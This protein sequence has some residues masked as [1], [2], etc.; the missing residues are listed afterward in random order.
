MPDTTHHTAKSLFKRQIPEEGSNAARL[1]E[2][3]NKQAFR[4]E[5]TRLAEK[6]QRLE[7][8]KVTPK[9]GCLFFSISPL[10]RDAR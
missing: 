5:E 6:Q 8:R 7:N 4:S 1:H 9:P 3:R 2:I 10:T